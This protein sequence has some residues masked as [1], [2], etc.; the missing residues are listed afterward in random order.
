MEKGH[1]H[2][3]GT[4][5]GHGT[6]PKNVWNMAGLP[7]GGIAAAFR[8]QMSDFG[9]PYQGPI[10]SN[11][12]FN[13]MELLQ[14]RQRFLRRAHGSRQQDSGAALQSMMNRVMFDPS[15]DVESPIRTA[16]RILQGASG[17]HIAHEFLQG[18][19]KPVDPNN[20]N[21]MRGKNLL[22]LDLTN[23]NWKYFM[24]D[25]DTLVVQRAGAL[26]A[27]S[28]F[29]GVSKPYKFRLA[30]I[31]APETEHAG[32][33]GY[34]RA[35]PYAY[36]A[37]EA[38][39][40]MVSNARNLSLVIDPQNI[41]YGRQVATVF[42]DSHN[43]NMELIRRGM[44]SYLPFKKKGSREMYS[45]ASY[46][47]ASNMAR[48]SGRGMWKAPF[49]QAY[50]DI[51]S[52]S[53]QTITF[54]T[55]TQIDKIAQNATMMSASSLMRNAQEQGFYSTANAIGAAEIGQRF[56][57]TGYKPNFLG[58]HWKEIY[59]F[60]GQ[61]TPHKAYMDQML[62]ETSGLMKTK[63]GFSSEKVASRN[64]HALDKSLSLD[65]MGTSTGIWS[66]RKLASYEHYGAS[67]R[68]A[69]R[70]R[71]MEAAQ[72]QANFAMFNSSINHH[73]M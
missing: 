48:V 61:N 27:M 15:G 22:Q 31:D 36:A 29:F 34:H 65:T 8:G 46:E 69:R 50:E 47:A 6:D 40:A 19:F 45:S 53:G 2:L 25:A 18:D 56:K 13:Q 43:M 68:N 41:T 71:S 72:Q 7:K 49:F 11:D 17:S 70:L 16:R 60:G 57:D 5:H 32:G 42:T 14:E 37:T 64:F 21:G 62:Q 73:R 51:V 23:G 20:L 54:N 1:T 30:G 26:N 44:S 4:P 10:V 24:E 52:A 9:S 33:S 39:Q 55:F 38:A 67:G 12:V 66:K 28:S 58:D 35:Q 59:T 63:G 3:A